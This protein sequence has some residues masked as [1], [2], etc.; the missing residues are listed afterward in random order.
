M[1]TL[2]EAIKTALTGDGSWT[3]LVT[4]G[5]KFREEWGRNGLEPETASYDT[6]GKLKLSCVL[7]FSTRVPAEIPNDS[8]RT[9]VHLWLYHDSSYELIQQ[10][11]DLARTILNKKQVAVTGKETPLLF[12]LNDG[13]EFTAEELQGAAGGMSRFAVQYLG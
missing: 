8:K 9:Y 7:T 4:G 3:A 11:Q 10:A 5:T 2:R 1:A 6:S 13:A 12:W